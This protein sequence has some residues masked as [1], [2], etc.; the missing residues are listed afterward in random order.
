MNVAN[1]W[2]VV[3]IFYLSSSINYLDRQILAAVSPS[4]MNEFHLN[5]EQY[6]WILTGFGLIYMLSSPLMGWFLD[7]VGLNLGTSI[8]LAWW[9]ISGMARG[10]TSGLTG[11]MATHGLMAIGESAGIPSTAKAAQTYLRQEERAI[12]SS[13]S[14]LGLVL[15]G[16]LATIIANYCISNWGWRSAFFAA[17][18][19]GFLWIPLW[20]WA[21]K[22][23]PAQPAS[24]ESSGF[25]VRSILKLPQTWG[26]VI[27]NVLSLGIFLFWTFWTN[28]YFVRT[29]G[30][31]VQD[32]NNLSPLLQ[33][34]SLVGS[35]LGGWSSMQL[36]RRG[37]APLA[38][39]RRVYLFGA[40]GMMLSAIV[41]LA[42][43]VTWAVVF[44]S[45]SYFASSA[46]SVNL[47]TMPLDA[48]GGSSAA[49]SVS[50]LTGGY[51]LLQLFAYPLIGR[52]ADQYGFAPICIA[53][54]FPPMLAYLIL[55]LTKSRASQT[56]RT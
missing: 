36:I 11:L 53:I 33:A 20:W 7:K 52:V 40:I 2:W 43:N 29:F 9:S 6:G 39:R 21:S 10:F 35:F 48:Y 19:L 34:I 22:K 23:A 25:D 3:A 50:L 31:T 37:W 46:A 16:L 14:Q 17:G 30:M 13:M 49:F 41:P 28:H 12:G 38:A 42:P 55:E 54:A 24:V 27:A 1:R 32:A 51:G 56:L 18:W 47:Y 44:I 5:Y 8:A 15:G 26:F 4:F 45:L